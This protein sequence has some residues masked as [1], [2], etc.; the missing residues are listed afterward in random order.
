MRS[1]RDLAPG[2]IALSL[3]AGPATAAPMS[4]VTTIDY[5]PISVQVGPT[6][7]SSANPADGSRIVLNWSTN[8]M[9]GT[10]LEGDLIDLTAT[11]FGETSPGV[12]TEIFQD[13]VV[14]GGVIQPIG[15]AARDIPGFGFDFTFD[16][17]VFAALGAAEGLEDF[18]NVAPPASPTNS[19]LIY[20]LIVDPDGLEDLNFAFAVARQNG[21][22]VN[23]LSTQNL[24][25]PVVDD[26]VSATISTRVQVIPLPATLPLLLAGIGGV[27]LIRRRPAT[28]Q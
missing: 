17:D 26:T 23:P 16:L 10:V 19:D 7:F 27:A 20:N 2:A 12:F 22:F 28:Q 24:S 6:E 18:D 3:V 1:F 13:V 9:S 25:D 15:G 8:L 11:L 14:S 5:T 4:F 21:V